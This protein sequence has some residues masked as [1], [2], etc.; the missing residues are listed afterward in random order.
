M[1]LTALA[2]SAIITV[3]AESNLTSGI[4]SV[5]NN[6]VVES[7]ES[8]DVEYF[9]LLKNQIADA[10]QYVQESEIKKNTPFY[11][12]LNVSDERKTVVNTAILLENKIPYQWGAKTAD[13]GWTKSFEDGNGLDC[14][15]F[16]EWAY[17]TALDIDPGEGTSNISSFIT[18]ISENELQPGDIGLKFNGGSYYI[19]ATGAVIANPD[20]NGDGLQEE[21]VT[22][23]ANHVGIYVGKDEEG[24]E[25]WCHCN[26]TDNT[27]SINNFSGFTYFGTILE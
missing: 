27:V 18:E 16:V 19:D 20:M 23:V 14:S 11:G 17:K 7:C 3:Q 15:G 2:A 26:A 24:N 6:T 9:D 25:L 21:G 13:T 12:Y 5:L 8:A 4:T 22:L 1:F 10:R